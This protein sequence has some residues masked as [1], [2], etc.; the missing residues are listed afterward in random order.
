MHACRL[1]APHSCRASVQLGHTFSTRAAQS[2]S[3]LRSRTT[4]EVPEAAALELLGLTEAAADLGLVAVFWSWMAAESS[5]PVLQAW[6][7]ASTCLRA[8]AACCRLAALSL[9][10]ASCRQH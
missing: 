4:L 5:R 7:M 2:S 1:S 3:P 6:R 10:F 8:A 9:L